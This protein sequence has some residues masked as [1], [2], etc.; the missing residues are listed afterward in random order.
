MWRVGAKARAGQ[1]GVAGQ[2][3]GTCHER[4]GDG[5]GERGASEGALHHSC[6]GRGQVH[7]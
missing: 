4:W 1:A 5:V 3:G 7:G 6:R 2:A